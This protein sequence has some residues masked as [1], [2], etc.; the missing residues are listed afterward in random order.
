M[1]HCLL[2]KKK[3]TEMR[4]IELPAPLGAAFA[5]PASSFSCFDFCKSVFHFQHA[6]SPLLASP[7]P[8]P[9]FSW[10]SS[11][12]I[13]SVVFLSPPHRT[14]DTQEQ[15]SSPPSISR[16]Q[17]FRRAHLDTE[18]V[19]QR[20]SC[21]APHHLSWLLWKAPLLKCSLEKQSFSLV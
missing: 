4:E 20:P 3:K 1:N 9:P 17:G 18:A 16:Y 11:L 21:S 12:L 8:S 5:P 14:E 10:D 2:L 7:P 6:P 19:T 13:I 15:G